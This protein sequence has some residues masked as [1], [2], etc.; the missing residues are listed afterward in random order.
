MNHIFTFFKTFLLA[1][2]ILVFGP[3]QS[4]GQKLLN[5]QISITVNRQPVS[6]IL[7]T[8]GNQAGFY[9]SYNS[10]VIPG[11]S[12]AS[13][14]AREKSVRKI[15]DELL[16]G[17]FQYKE[18]GNYIILQRAPYEKF[19][20]ITGKISDKETSKPV[21]FASVYS[22]TLLVSALSDD[23][24]YFRLK[25]RERSFP[26]NLTI[27]KVGY[28]DTSIVI[29]AEPKGELLI[30]ISQ[31]AID[32]E[33]VFVNN[34]AGDRTWLARL[35]VSSRLRAQSRNI[36]R[37]FV[38]LPYQASLT[39]G[40]GTHGRMSAQVINKFSLNLLGG[41]T[42]GVNGLE[43]AGGF[44]ISKKDVKYV[45][46][47]GLFNIVSRSVRGV[48]VSGLFNH[49]IDS[50][51]G[52]Q[53][54]GFG[55][56]IGS[57][58][59]GAQVS[60]FFN[61]AFSMNGIQISGAGNLAGKAS[62]GV[63]ISSLVNRVS[64][65]FKGTQV[66]GGLNLVRKNM[67]GVQI[68]GTGNVVRGVV[69]GFQLAPFNYAKNLKGTQL[70]IVNIADSSS[71]YSI[72]LINILKHGKS[73]ISVYANDIVPLNIAW[74]TGSRKIYSFLMIG[75]AI[76]GRKKAYT[77]GIGLGKE[78]NLYQ[79]LGLI[80]EISSQNLYLGSWEDAPALTRLQAAL[81][82]KLSKRLSLSAGPSFT[83]MYNK[84][85]E[86][87]AGYQS[88]PPKTYALFDHAKNASSWL[89]WQIGLSWQY[90]DLL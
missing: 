87:K 29:Q 64:G 25:L 37:F 38:S 65:D 54:A 1:S 78:F 81:D 43:I 77:F 83:L 66:V 70:G 28:G 5:K 18:M 71:G 35:F 57:N 45:Q 7:Q 32:L 31:K 48:Q 68:A 15:L 47:A 61:K 59:E 41:Y 80:T 34:S 88:Y 26:M 85:S 23:A 11:D 13:F 33:E 8:I 27:S 44:N 82:L 21:D 4:Y 20:Y 49:V 69:S 3:A 42:A 90:G 16:T 50:L 60:G 62:A 67:R 30:D 9:F 17:Q 89:G 79:K 46:V 52:A 19:L 51:S 12:I 24:G 6:E 40:L 36:S 76:D 58:L 39:P 73:A 84:K 63:Q 74:K 72:G 75:S 55:N 53:I 56:V 10:D 22:R 86:P 2:I 14:S